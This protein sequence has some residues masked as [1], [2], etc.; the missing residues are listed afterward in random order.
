MC[1]YAVVV[2]GFQWKITAMLWD[3]SMYDVAL[4]EASHENIT[5]R[6]SMSSNQTLILDKPI[7]MMG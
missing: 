6:L 3:V 1:L 4:P 5:A 7:N 2:V